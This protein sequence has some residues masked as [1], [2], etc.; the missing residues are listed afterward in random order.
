MKRSLLINLVSDLSMSAEQCFEVSC[1]VLDDKFET[2]VLLHVGFNEK[3]GLFM[4]V[5][6]EK[7]L[8]E[9][10]DLKLIGLVTMTIITNFE[11]DPSKNEMFTDVFYDQDG[12]LVT[13]VIEYE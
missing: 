1:T 8:P 5:N 10:S 3:T 2:E 4:Q 9:L 11:A 13:L 12:D 7:S 6:R